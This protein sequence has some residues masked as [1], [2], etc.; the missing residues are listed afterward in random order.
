[1]ECI[2]PFSVVFNNFI[3]LQLSLVLCVLMCLSIRA[4]GA[5]VILACR[6]VTK[7]E[8]VTKEMQTET[9]V[10]GKMKVMKL[11]LASLKSIHQFVDD[12]K[13]GNLLTWYTPTPH[14]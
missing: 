13:K 2:T 4:I 9:G 11:D 1:M 3:T 6:D 8:E 7:G 14:I 5:N 10:L 12:F